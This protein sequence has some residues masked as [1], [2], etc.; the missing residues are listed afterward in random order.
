MNEPAGDNPGKIS[1]RY[2]RCAD[3]VRLPV[4][5]NIH[6]LCWD[7]EKYSFFQKYPVNLQISATDFMRTPSD[8][9]CHSAALNKICAVQSDLM[10][11][12]FENNIDPDKDFVE[13]ASVEISHNSCFFHHQGIENRKSAINL[14]PLQM[15]VVV[16][17]FLRSLIFHLMDN[18]L[19]SRN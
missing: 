4:L 18:S 2:P 1:A 7:L 19:F 9:C 8:K 14:S 15:C 3:N 12:W 5:D 17:T 13:G 11:F 6:R 10:L 16:S